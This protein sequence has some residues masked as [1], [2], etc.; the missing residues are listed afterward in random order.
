MTTYR[1]VAK[2]RDEFGNTGEISAAIQ[3][4]DLPSASG[5]TSLEA[6]YDG[7]AP[8]GESPIKTMDFALS[9]ERKDAIRAWKIAIVNATQ[10]V[11]KDRERNFGR[12]SVFL[13]MGTA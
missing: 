6:K 13:F 1:A 5:S 12:P 9:V 7:F 2:V 3:V 8:N 4:A 11:Q 10:G